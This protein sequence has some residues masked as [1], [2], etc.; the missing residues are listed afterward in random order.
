MIDD[1]PSTLPDTHHRFL[2]GAIETL[3]R[4]P[5]IVGI[6]AG[7]S[8]VSDTMDEF[9][10]LDLVLAIEPERHGE[11]LA[12]AKAIAA[13]L[14]RLLAAF[15]GDHVGE[16]RLLICLYD[17]PLLHVDLKFVALPDV[18]RRVEDPVVLWQR[19]RRVSTA[20]AAG[21]ARYPQPDAQWIEDRFWVWVHYGVAKIARGE[22]FEAIDSLSFLRATVLGPL[23]LA[24]AGARPSGVRKIER[25]APDVAQALAGTIALPDRAACLAALRSAVELYRSLRGVGDGLELRRDAEDAALRY[26][27]E[28]SRRAQDGGP[29]G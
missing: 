23:A 18:A 22:I 10:D 15:T 26:L 3:S 21:R 17:E 27:A 25:Q 16:P 7:G 11:V 13:G 1:V 2:S 12:A 19:G 20:L 14:G 28:T 4:D 5:R 6:A 29:P 9:S 8:Y 24:R